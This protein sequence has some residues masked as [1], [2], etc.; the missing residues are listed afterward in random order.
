MQVITVFFRQV[1]IYFILFYLLIPLLRNSFI[2]LFN[3]LF[4]YL[5][6]VN[7]QTGFVRIHLVLSLKIHWVF[8]LF[9]FLFVL[10]CFVGLVFVVVPIRYHLL[11]LC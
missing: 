4:S 9:V 7:F 11:I 10:F 3:Y 1:L 5:V 2:Y 8:C 6:S